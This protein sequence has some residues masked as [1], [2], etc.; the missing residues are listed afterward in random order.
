MLSLAFSATDSMA[1]AAIRGASRSSVRRPTRCHDA[2]AR[3][4]ARSPWLSAVATD[5]GATARPLIETAISDD[6]LDNQC[7]RQ[8]HEPQ[9]PRGRSHANGHSDNQ[10]SRILKSAPH[11]KGS[12]LPRVGRRCL[13]HHENRRP[14]PRHRL[15]LFGGSPNT[16]SMTHRQAIAPGSRCSRSWQ[17]LS[18][19]VAFPSRLNFRT[20]ADPSR[21]SM[22]QDHRHVF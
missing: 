18:R 2:S 6:R 8:R 5:R 19:R 16:R 14:H 12:N 20:V 15:N 3:A 7:K 11:N 10:P 1:A 4:A 21:P 9:A 17:H 13:R 22:R